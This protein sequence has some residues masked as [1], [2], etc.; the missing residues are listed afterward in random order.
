MPVGGAASRLAGQQAKRMK[1]ARDGA[2]RRLWKSDCKT[3]VRKGMCQ[4]TCRKEKRRSRIVDIAVS[5]K[6]SVLG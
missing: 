2:E 1:D 3:G 6:K 5:F 4:V